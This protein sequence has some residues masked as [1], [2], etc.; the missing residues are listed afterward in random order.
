MQMHRRCTNLRRGGREEGEPDTGPHPRACR[1]FVRI[2]PD[3]GNPGGD[4]A[5]QIYPVLCRAGDPP[6]M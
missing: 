1:R 3:P 2:C 5:S 4:V 6:S